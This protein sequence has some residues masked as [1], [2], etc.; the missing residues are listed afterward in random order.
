VKP[1][2]VIFVGTAG[3]FGRAPAL[4]LGGAVTARQIQLVSSAVLR[5]QAFFPAPLPTTIHTDPRL[6]RALR[7][8]LADVACPLAI[9]RTPAAARRLATTGCQ[10][11]TLEAFAVA[12][13][14]APLPFAAVLGLSN[15]VGPAGHA[16]WRTHAAAASAAACAAV[17]AWLARN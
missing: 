16:Q 12:R 2:A 11:E 7:L 10:L 15:Q 6:R 13:A 4:P 14:A 5:G 17:L 1:R 8:N 9:T 3:V